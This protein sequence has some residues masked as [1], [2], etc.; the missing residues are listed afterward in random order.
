METITESDVAG[1]PVGFIDTNAPSVDEKVDDGEETTGKGAPQDPKEVLKLAREALDSAEKSLEDEDKESDEKSELRVDVESGVDGDRQLSSASEAIGFDKER[2]DMLVNDNK[3]SD[4][5]GVVVTDDD[6]NAFIDALVTGKRYKSSVVMF[7]GRLLLK[8]RAR[9]VGESEAIDSY[10]RRC[11][12]SGRI[13]VGV[14]YS[15]LMRLCLL[16][17]D[18]E[19]LGDEQYPEMEKP[20]IAVSGP[21]GVKDPPWIKMLDVW[22]SKPEGL[23]NAILPEVFKFEVKY[24]EMVK[25]G[26]DGNFWRTG[27]STGE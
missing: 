25:R 13:K 9:T 22:R 1:K 16:V 18:V 7:G 27:E 26:I 3:K 2:V 21:D 15:D 8:M 10:L 14:E 4:I 20:L 11:V 23:I 19:Q 5:D 12:V 24:A 6:K 17:S